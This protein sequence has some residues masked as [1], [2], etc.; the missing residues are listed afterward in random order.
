VLATGVESR[1]PVDPRTTFSKASDERVY[2][3]LRIENPERETTTVTMTWERAEG[4]GPN[5]QS[6]E[7]DVYPNPTHVTFAFTGTQRRAGRYACVIRDANAEVLGRA[8]FEL[9][10]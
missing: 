10:D 3:Y 7:M 6:R 5:D 2:C 9:T 4:P 8:E 1:Q